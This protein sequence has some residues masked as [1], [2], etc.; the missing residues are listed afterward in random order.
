MGMKC[1]KI[2]AALLVGLLAAI[3][4][5]GVKSNHN[6]EQIDYVVETPSIE[7]DQANISKFQADN[8]NMAIDTAIW[9]EHHYDAG[10]YSWQNHSDAENFFEVGHV[11]EKPGIDKLVEFALKK[12]N[13]C[14]SFAATIFF[15]LSTAALNLS[16]C[17]FPMLPHSG[18][19]FCKTSMIKCC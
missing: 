1:T 16:I 14:S 9:T 6:D 11:E 4:W 10:F 5:L 2:L 15:K 13:S 3:I 7:E 8:F 17:T 19:K 18:I 12:N